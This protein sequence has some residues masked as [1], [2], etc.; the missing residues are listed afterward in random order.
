M[1]KIK[2]IKNGLLKRNSSL[3]SYALKTG[4]SIVKNRNDPK[5]ILEDIIGV[6]PEK[7]VDDLS[8][9]KGSIMKAGQMLSQYGEFYLSPQI[10]EKLKLLH[11]MTHFLDF[12]VISSQLNETHLE[13]LEIEKQPIAAASIG[14]V[15]KAKLKSTGQFVILKIQYKG[16]DKAIGGDMFFL[17]ALTSSLKIF[18]KGID[19]TDVFKEIERVLKHEMDYLEEIKSINKYSELLDDQ[20]FKVPKVYSDFSSDKVICLEYINGTHLSNLNSLN[21]GQA[22]R[23]RIG[24]KLLELFLREI[25]EFNLVQTDAHGG[26]YFVSENGDSVALLDFGACLEFDKDLIKFYQGFLKNSFLLNEEGF[27]KTLH[28]FMEIS[29]KYLTYERDS[30]WKYITLISD[31]WRSSD[32]DWGSTDIQNEIFEEGQ[33]LRK[34]LSFKSIPAHFIFLDRKVLGIFTLLRSINARVNM[35]EIF[36][37]IVK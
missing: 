18:P 20:F 34:T 21:L 19:T 36:E 28:E 17:K 33:K 13:N 11:N 32:F 26:N 25:F 31:P 16:I 3:L 12:D 10:N 2:N 9:Y 6:H 37:K 27:F 24:S 35:R 4:V 15:H 30:M 8:H 23:D 22:K 14:Q 1:K 5:Q 7:I 29:G